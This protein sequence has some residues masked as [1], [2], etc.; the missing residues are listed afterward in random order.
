MELFQESQLK[1]QIQCC[2]VRVKFQ[3]GFGDPK[4]LSNSIFCLFSIKIR[5]LAPESGLGAEHF[6]HCVIL[7]HP[8]KEWTFE[9]V[10]SHLLSPKSFF[11]KCWSFWRIVLSL[12]TFLSRSYVQR[13]DQVHGT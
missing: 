9:I 2:R 12:L 6:K 8:I 4:S 11:G 1:Y 10:W 3:I 5:N 7:G 13:I